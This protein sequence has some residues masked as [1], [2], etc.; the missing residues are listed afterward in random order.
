[1]SKA[2]EKISKYEEEEDKFHSVD[3]WKLHPFSINSQNGEQT[4]VCII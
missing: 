2:Y 1:M 3:S 4:R